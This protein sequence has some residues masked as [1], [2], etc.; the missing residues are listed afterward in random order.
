M[1]ILIQILYQGDETESG[2]LRTYF[3][4]DEVVLLDEPFSALDAITKKEMHKW[5]KDISK[6]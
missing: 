4:S 6:I 2:V 1:K 3:A 5:Y